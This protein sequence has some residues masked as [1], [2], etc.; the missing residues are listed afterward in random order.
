MNIKDSKIYIAGHNGMVGSS[1]LRVLKSYGYKNIIGLSRDKLNLINQDEVIDFFK[2]EK[3]TI[4][5]NAAGKVGGINANNLNPYEFLMQNLQIQNNLID[6]SLNYG[7]NKFIFIGTSSIYPRLSPQPIKEE[8]LLTGP[9]EPTNEGYA[10]AKIAGIKACNAINKQFGKDF[11]SLLPS[12]L[13]GVNDN[14]DLESAHVIQALIR[15]FVE[16]S[17]NNHPTVSLWGSGSPKREFTYVDDFSLAVMFCL[18]NQ[19]QKSMYN[20]GNGDEVSI[21]ELA[22]IIK[23]VVGFK[24][25]L[26]WDKSKPDGIPRK[27]MDSSNFKSCGWNSTIS[28]KDG[29][30]T[31]LEWYLKNRT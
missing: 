16:A 14:F 5:I 26:V 4:V 9:F 1:I 24:G 19:L 17:E 21:K 28:L 20:V 3:P 10:I 31:T 18:E 30:K 13:Y 8:Y 2:K 25:E 23:D 27:L 15:K 29:I 7:V 11:I 12:N 22:I 6:S